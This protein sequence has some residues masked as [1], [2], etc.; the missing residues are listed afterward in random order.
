MRFSFY[1]S[2][3]QIKFENK[4]AALPLVVPLT[5]SMETAYDKIKAV[6]KKIK[7]SIGMIYGAYSITYWSGKLLPRFVNKMT[8]A[9]VSKKITAG[10]SNTPGPL[11]PFK[12]TCE[13]TGVVI[14]S[15]ST[16]AYIMTSGNLGFIFCAL[17]QMNT[18]R[19]SLCTDDNVVDH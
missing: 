16:N 17:S 14:R 19:M 11:K 1:P 7:S 2:R 10:F 15:M 3:E 9:N 18:I 5:S 6:T 8:I 4:F 12:Y 13:K